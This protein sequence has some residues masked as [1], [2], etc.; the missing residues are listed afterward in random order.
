MQPALSRVKSSPTSLVLVS[1][2]T[3]PDSPLAFT[4]PSGPGKAGASTQGMGPGT[5]GTAPARGAVLPLKIEAVTPADED[6]YAVYQYLI[7]GDKDQT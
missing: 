7:G 2:A 1:R 6:V 3:P 4:K 5:T